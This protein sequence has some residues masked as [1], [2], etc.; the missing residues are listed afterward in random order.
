MT[1]TTNDLTIH[2]SAEYGCYVAF[3]GPTP[4]DSHAIGE[5]STREDA[6]ADY[7]HSR[8]DG[9]TASILSPYDAGNDCWTL[10]DGTYVVRFDTRADAVAYAE[11]AQYITSPFVK[12][13]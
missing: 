2:L 3:E 12:E 10:T 11:A 6:I 9:K 8:H 7:W 5:G 4:E 1:L 13:V